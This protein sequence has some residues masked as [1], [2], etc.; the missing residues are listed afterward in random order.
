MTDLSLLACQ[1]AVPPTPDGAAR[2]AH[3]AALA[4]RIRSVATPGTHDLIVLPELSAIEYSEAA[5]ARLDDLAEPL[6]GA[7]FR[8]FSRLARELGST[9]VYGF[10]RRGEDGRDFICQAAVGP[11]GALLGYFDKLHL[12]QFG[13]SAEAGAFHPG[14]H[15]FIFGLKGVRIAPVI[16]YDIR[17][18][19]LAGRLAAEGVDLVLQC[20]AYA[21]DLSFHSWRP[22]VVTRAMEHGFAWLGLNRA[23]DDWGGSIWCPGFAD[24]D[25]PEKVLGTADCFETLSLSPG[26]RRENAA[27]L[28]IGRDQRGDYDQLSVFHPGQAFDD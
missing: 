4:D 10:A 1:I 6:D 8:V 19:G 7:S 5:F 25:S 11:D 20:S 15:L 28:P 23:G 16:C 14:D 18:P 21:R 3:L 2:D 22:F 13:A 17:F 24:G 27:R 9:V 26:F 12:A